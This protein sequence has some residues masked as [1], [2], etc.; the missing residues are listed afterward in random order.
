MGEKIKTKRKQTNTHYG[1]GDYPLAAL[2]ALHA[3]RREQGCGPIPHL[4]S[5]VSEESKQRAL[6][7]PGCNPIKQR[8]RDRRGQSDEEKGNGDLL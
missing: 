2:L 5:W 4:L 6:G 8:G 3:G 7:E 1:T